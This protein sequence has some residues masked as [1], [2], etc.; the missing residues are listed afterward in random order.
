MRTSASGA[1]LLCCLCVG[2]GGEHKRGVGGTWPARVG[3]EGPGAQSGRALSS[4]PA[5]AEHRV[6]AGYE[7]R[8]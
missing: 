8:A 1:G 4:L 5:P 7:H 3:H 2:G 6:R